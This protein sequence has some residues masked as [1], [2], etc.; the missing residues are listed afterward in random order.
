[1][2]WIAIGA[3]IASGLIFPLSVLL[4]SRKID[5]ADKKRESR[6]EE[7]AEARQRESVLIIQSLT[8]IGHLSEATAI[9]IKEQKVNGKMDTAL[10]YYTEAK[11][12]MHTYLL[13]QNARINHG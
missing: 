11:D 13:Q 8:A 12:E 4:I 9:A 5:R 10:K 3:A 7:L 2:N 1:M 6:D